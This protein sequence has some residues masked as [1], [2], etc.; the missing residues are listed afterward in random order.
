AVAQQHPG[1][2]DAEVVVVGREQVELA[3]AVDV[4]HRNAAGTT[5]GARAREAELELIGE[6]VRVA[7][8]VQLR[9]AGSAARER[10]SW[11]GAG[12]AGQHGEAHGDGVAA[13]QRLG[14]VAGVVDKAVG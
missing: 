4:G 6:G 11:A 1:R 12:A 10:G 13:E 9:G 2:V 8:E 14:G 3:V 5:V 7:G